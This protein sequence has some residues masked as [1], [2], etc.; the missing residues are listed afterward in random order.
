MNSIKIQG[1][2]ATLGYN[3]DEVLSQLNNGLI[4]NNRFKVLNRLRMGSGGMSYKVHD[5]NDDNL[6][7]LKFAYQGDFETSTGIFQ[8]HKILNQLP[9]HPN[10]VNLKGKDTVNFVGNAGSFKTSYLLLEYV[11]GVDLHNLIDN[12]QLT[13]GDSVEI[14]FQ[15]AKALSHLHESRVCHRDIYPNNIIWSN[16]KATLID[17]DKACYTNNIVSNQTGI[18]QFVPPDL[19]YY[20]RSKNEVNLDR[21][22]YALGIT[23]CLCITG[24][25]PVK[26]MSLRQTAENINIPPKFKR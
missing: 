18:I 11:E 20:G 4:I 3:V 12:K 16:A 6:C 10:I 9:K 19:D 15:I 17:F 7:V 22:I 25:Y 14:A 21:D 13:L 2:T 1:Y 5:Q 8:E 23:L 24:E 26:N